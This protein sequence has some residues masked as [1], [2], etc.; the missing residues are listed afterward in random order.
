MKKEKLRGKLSVVTA[1]QR[2]SRLGAASPCVSLTREPA[3]H[4]QLLLRARIAD[5]LLVQALPRGPKGGSDGSPVCLLLWDRCTRQDVG[6]VPDEGG[7]ER[8][9]H[10]LDH[11]RRF[12]AVAGLAHPGRVHAR[13]D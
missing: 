3:R 1:V 13:G 9:P 7:A 12:A 2:S 4:H 10:L 11:D 5:S 6:G 8:S